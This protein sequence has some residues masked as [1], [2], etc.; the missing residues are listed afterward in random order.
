[1][2]AVSPAPVP[3]TP[4]PSRSLD[5]GARQLWRRARLPLVLALVVLGAALLVALVASRSARGLLDPR[6]TDGS[7]SRAIAALLADAGVQV[8]LV[9][10]TDDALRR[11]GPSTTLVVVRSALLQERQVERLSGVTA[12][13]VVVE[14]T[15]EI[16]D[17]LVPD[18]TV[19]G[20]LDVTERDPACRLPAAQRAGEA[21]L[22]GLAFEATAQPGATT[23][24]CYA[25][26]GRA[27]LVRVETA[28]RSVT[29]LGSAD[30]LV[31]DALAESGNAALALG[32]LGE[33]PRVVWYLPSLGDALAGERRSLTDLLPAG[34]RW[35]A[36]QAAIAVALLAV[37]RA[38]RLGP[39]VPEPLPVVVRAAEAVE[40]R[41]RL[42]RRGRAR[43]R[44][45]EA[46]RTATRARLATRVGLST[47][48]S[49]TEIVEA[50]AAR[51]GRPPVQVGDLLYGGVPPDDPALVRLADDLDT[52]EQ[53]VRRP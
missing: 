33:H 11:A 20:E 28:R 5:P 12:D 49:A 45:A 44:A 17:R 26:G 10:T 22:G 9:R 6:A 7:G 23:E 2:T 39:V 8:D 37:W 32:L 27:A 15:A 40:G 52:L 30:P 50:V 51:A 21:V 29:A 47:R 43:D 48:A 34:W 46:L 13:V 36:G 4:P 41:A 3:P 53:E 24:L 14:P 18:V 38:R 42:Y 16:L 19:N 25:E 35:A 1:M 31:N